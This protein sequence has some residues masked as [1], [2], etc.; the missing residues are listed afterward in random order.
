MK[1]YCLLLSVFLMSCASHR[2]KVSGA[3]DQAQSQHT[4]LLR[5]VQAQSSA[6][7]VCFTE[8]DQHVLQ[9]VSCQNDTAL[10]LF[11]PV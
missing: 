10:P 5:I 11:L 6:N 8:V 4:F 9:A 7:W 2:I 1:V 3:A